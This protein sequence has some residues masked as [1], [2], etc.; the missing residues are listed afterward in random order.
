MIV[1]SSLKVHLSTAW[2][3]LR[4]NRGKRLGKKIRSIST[5]FLTFFTSSF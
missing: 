5:S 1:T 4:N 2:L 3:L